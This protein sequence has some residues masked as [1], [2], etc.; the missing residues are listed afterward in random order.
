LL[1]ILRRLVLWSVAFENGLANLEGTDRVWFNC[2]V[3]QWFLAFESVYIQHELET[4]QE[5]FFNAKMENLKNML[6]GPGVREAWEWK[7]ANVDFSG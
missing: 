7:T 4:L 2:I 6:K 3:G 1:G 5:D